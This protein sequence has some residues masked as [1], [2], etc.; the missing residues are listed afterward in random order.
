MKRHPPLKGVCRWCDK[1]VVGPRGQPTKGTWHSECVQEFKLIHWPAATR[2][3]VLARDN[4][5]CARCHRD[6]EAVRRAWR[7]TKRLWEWLAR[8][9]FEDEVNANRL[10]IEAWG[11]I[12]SMVNRDVADQ[13]GRAGAPSLNSAWQHDHIRPLIEANGDLSFWQLGNIQT[14]CTACHV[15]K[16]KEDNARRRAENRRENQLALL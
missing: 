3:A 2:A 10:K 1:A 13:M 14:L 11:E 7:E 15:Q 9:H 6:S 16:G 5:V 8:R 12:Y 4:G